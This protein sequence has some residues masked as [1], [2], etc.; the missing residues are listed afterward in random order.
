LVLLLGSDDFDEREQ[1][2][3]DLIEIGVPALAA[4]RRAAMSADPEVATR[5]KACIP[6]IEV[7]EKVMAL[8]PLLKS[9]SA[10]DRADT[11]NLL[12]PFGPGAYKAVPALIVALDDDDLEVRLRTVNMLGGIG[13]AAGPAVD[14]LIRMLQDKN[15]GEDIRFRVA[16]SL[17]DIGHP[18]RKAAPVLLHILEA[19][20]GF[21]RLGALH[22][23]GY[24]GHH[25]KKVVPALL[26]ALEH[27]DI[28]VCLGAGWS[29]GQ[30]GEQPDLVVPALVRFLNKHRGDT[31]FDVVRE[32]FV[33]ALQGFGANSKLALPFLIATVKDDHEREGI[34]KEALVTL[35]RI[36]PAA[37][38]AIPT[39]KALLEKEGKYG[40]LTD[41]LKETLESIKP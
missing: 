8:V 30:L 33:V 2:G 18:A 15:Q 21:M 1:A 38:E 4:L 35:A 29:L 7:N 40:R 14:R 6:M 3:A 16:I 9:K 12:G 39:L 32:K 5:A 27:K 17:A 25:D 19:E 22:A 13:P 41:S 28:N 37:R 11:V 34:R 31:D 10:I 26:K 36:G 20:S 23:L 24:V